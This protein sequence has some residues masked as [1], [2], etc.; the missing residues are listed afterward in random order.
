VPGTVAPFIVGADGPDQLLFTALDNLIAQ[1]R[2]PVMIAI[3]IANGSN[4]RRAPQ[5]A[6]TAARLRRRGTRITLSTFRR[7]PCPS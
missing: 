1:K 7:T 6:R 2:V 4:A 3:S 5:Q